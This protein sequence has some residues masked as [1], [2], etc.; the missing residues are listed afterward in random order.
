[1]QPRSWEDIDRIE[2]SKP[3]STESPP[4][5][6]NLHQTV[7]QHALNLIFE[8]LRVRFEDAAEN[9]KKLSGITKEIKATVLKI[10]NTSQILEFAA[11]GASL[12]ANISTGNALGIVA[13]ISSMSGLVED[14]STQEDM[15]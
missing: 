15:S 5:P 6:Q 10:T 7:K 3:T 2:S 11:V 8:S 13:N 14:L 1:M 12:A 9:L 4:K